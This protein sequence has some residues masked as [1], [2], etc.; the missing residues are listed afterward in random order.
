MISRLPYN[1]HLLQIKMNVTVKQGMCISY[2]ETCRFITVAVGL[3]ITIKMLK[4]YICQMESNDAEERTIHRLGMLP[5][6][7]RGAERGA[8]DDIY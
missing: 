1:I 6:V 3:R 7:A 2:R 8:S 5:G 4:T